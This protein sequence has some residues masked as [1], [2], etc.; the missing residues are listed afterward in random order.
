MVV[1]VPVVNAVRKYAGLIREFSG[2]REE[3]TDSWRGGGKFNDIYGCDGEVHNVDNDV[4][5]AGYLV[6]VGWVKSGSQAHG[7]DMLSGNS[8]RKVDRSEY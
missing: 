1:S 3:N 6:F 5:L 2:K 4:G 8:C 7:E